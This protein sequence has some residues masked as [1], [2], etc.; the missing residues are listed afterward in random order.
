[1][2]K[3]TK[4]D[5]PDPYMKPWMSKA[6]KKPGAL[7]RAL[8]VPQGKKI[9]PAKIEAAKHK[10]GHLGKMANLAQVFSKFRPA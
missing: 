5:S 10:G 7:H 6:V 8:H 3:L 9:P 1:M 2:D 4:G